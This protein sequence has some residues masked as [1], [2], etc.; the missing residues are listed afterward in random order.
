MKKVNLKN[1][2]VL[3]TGGAGFI[4]SEL[5]RQ[6]SALGARV[7]VVDNLV[8]GRRGNLKGIL[9]RNVR[10]IVEDIRNRK[11]M[12]RLLKTT[13][14]LYHLACMGVRH[15]IHSP[16]ENHQV[17]AMGTLGLL[18][19]ARK[20]RVKRFVYVSSSEVYGNAL[21]TP[22]TETH[23]TSPLTVYGS[24][25]LAGDCYTRAFNRTYGFP[26]VV[27]RPF[28]SYGPRSHYEGD[29]GE[30]IPKFILRCLAGYPMVLFGDGRQTR[31]FTYVGDTAKGVLLAGLCN[32]ALGKTLNLGQGRETSIRELA[33]LVGKVLGKPQADIQHDKPRPGD[34]R[35]LCADI[36][37]ARNILGFQPTVT[38]EQGLKM[39]KAWYL[40]SSRLPHE[41]LKEERV[42]NWEP[43]PKTELV[44]GRGR[45]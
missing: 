12:A 37:Q 38:L 27:V 34:V 25:K 8:N 30:V 26:T 9:G 20:N 14:L 19:E 7:T 10:L 3:V 39:L 24:S 42:Y 35:R 5:V 15:S 18:V 22:M 13:D 2:R 4:G 6:L 29:S 44:R 32:E 36:T 21:R 31:D 11:S 43:P 23:P 41:L 45:L 40:N 28:N 17:N 1:D 33:L 16:V